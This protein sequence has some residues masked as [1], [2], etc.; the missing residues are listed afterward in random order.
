MPKVVLPAAIEGPDTSAVEAVAPRDA[1]SWELVTTVLDWMREHKCY[2]YSAAFRALTA[3]EEGDWRITPE[4]MNCNFRKAMKNPYVQQRLVERYR[5]LDLIVFQ[6]IETQWLSVIW[7]MLDIA[8]GRKGNSRDAAPAA[9]FL[10]NQKNDIL[11]RFEAG[12]A[13][14]GEHPA[15]QALRNFQ[16]QRKGKKVTARRITEE[17]TV[18]DDD[19]VSMETPVVDA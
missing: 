1:K 17:I 4:T 9:R 19:D 8:T 3:S 13:Q 16:S 18:S 15:L 10:E 5:A 6:T 14:V 7:N 11:A 2:N 12:E